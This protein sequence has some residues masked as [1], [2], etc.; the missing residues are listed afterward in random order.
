MQK[1]GS[2]DVGCGKYSYEITPAP[3]PSPSP[4]PEPTPPPTP[5]SEPPPPPPQDPLSAPSSLITLTPTV[6]TGAPTVC[7]KDKRKD[8]GQ[9]DVNPKKAHSVTDTFCDDHKD[10]EGHLGD[11]PAIEDSN[12]PFLEKNAYWFKV[13]WKPNCVSSSGPTLNLGQPIPEYGCKEALRDSF[14]KC[15]Y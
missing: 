9:H 4:S 15:K 10:M 14:D 8:C 13:L 11:W 3:S 5:P 12:Q 1:K 2:I 6:P 7:Y